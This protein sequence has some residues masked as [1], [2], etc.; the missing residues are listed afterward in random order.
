MKAEQNNRLVLVDGYSFLFRAYH[1][2]PPLTN[3]DGVVVGALYGY[4]NMILRIRK[5]LDASHFA[6]VLDHGDKTF[7]TEI[8][9]EYKA[10]RPPAPE[11]LKP[12]FP[13]VR[14]VTAA[15]NI[16]TLDQSGVEADDIIAT[17]ALKAEK[18]NMDVTII[19][20][21]KD[22]MQ[23][24]SD[25][26]KLYDPMKQKIIDRDA[27]FEKFAVYPDKIL[28]LLSLSGDSADNIPGVP[29][30]GPK[31]A[32]QLI[33]EYGSIEG[34]YQNIHKIKQPKRRETLANNKQ[35]AFLSRD[36]VKLKENVEII[37]EFSELEV[38]EINKTEL[39]CFFN[40]HGFKTL[41]SK[42]G[43][44]IVN[45]AQ[46]DNEEDNFN[47]NYVEITKENELHAAFKKINE[48][49]EIIIVTFLNN[50][51]ISTNSEIFAFI[52]SEITHDLLGENIT[53]FS[54]KLLKIDLE[55]ALLDK[56]IKKNFFDFKDFY[57]N[58]QHQNIFPNLHEKLNLYAE[59][60]L[61]YK[62]L[63]FL[64]NQPDD[65]FL[66]EKAV[67]S[68]ELIKKRFSTI[69][70]RLAKYKNILSENKQFA[71]FHNLDLPFLEVLADME[72]AG[73]K[74][75]IDKLYSLTQEFSKQIDV[76]Q[77]EIFDL[78]GEEFNIASPKQLG[79]ILFT[80][81]GIS[82]K[83]KSKKTKNLSTS[84]QVLEELSIAGY[85]IAAKILAWRRFSKLKNTYSEALPKQINQLSKRVHSSFS[86]TTT[87]TGRISSNNPN[88][89]NIP[90]RSKEGDRI[91]AA[92]ICENG[93]KLISADYSQIELRLLAEIGGVSKLQNA[94][95]HNIDVHTATASEVF[96]VPAQDVDAELRR[97]AKMI[98]FGII[99]GISSFGL[100]E[101]LNISRKEA[102][103]YIELYFKRY[104]EIK[105]YMERTIATCKEHG[106]VETILG[107]RLFF[108]N[109]DSNNFAL[110]NFAER[111]VINAPLQGS[112]AD[113][114][115]LAMI[116]LASHIKANN[117]PMRLILQIHDELIYEVKEDFVLEA[118]KLIKEY[119]EN[120]VKLKTPLIVEVNSGDNWH[121]I[122]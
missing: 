96:S 24:V 110:R 32:A 62:S 41:V 87:S 10:N 112:A 34:I 94:F 95:R 80:K 118:K 81:L 67:L 52:P 105:E 35:Q 108:N 54:D 38:Q 19:S 7:R 26:I 58:Y 53:G 44:E 8:Y 13:L 9:Q 66:P 116:N 83:K 106:F 61:D 59:N 111:A 76:L 90:V 4:S 122:H 71:L 55:R 18:R 100:A 12:Q 2:M 73:F 17:L 43:S 65:K 46:N 60:F 40:K 103:E 92:F 51:Y 82:A 49:S 74:I 119:M 88:L 117:L 33:N 68:A 23:L 102:K 107:R 114:I 72:K 42:I 64:A 25:K 63:A 89:Q 57:R 78:A 36:L 20:S 98:N 47:F 39:A 22:L 45:K 86:N 99:Y 37:N 16:A 113:I 30:I 121:E 109:L 48:A 120:A 104:E 77:K 28:D 14:D 3:P 85:E 101:R 1:S 6:V 75:S 50:L 56:T 93:C 97:K 115:K 69:Y 21:D 27:V 11:D 29:S 84:Q 70:V 91:R 79:E 5:E 31:T 15:M